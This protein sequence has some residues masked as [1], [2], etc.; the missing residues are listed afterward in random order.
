MGRKMARG[1]Q[2][3]RKGRG[4]VGDTYCFLCGFEAEDSAEFETHLEELRHKYNFKLAE[5]KERRSVC[6]V[7]HCLILFV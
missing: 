6:S 1:R 2:Q 5:F 4:K 3:R 7:I